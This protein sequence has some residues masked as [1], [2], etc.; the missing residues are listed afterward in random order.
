MLIKLISIATLCCVALCAG[1]SESNPVAPCQEFQSDLALTEL[2]VQEQQKQ[3]HSLQEQLSGYEDAP[4]SQTIV[5]GTLRIPAGSYSDSVFI[6]TADMK[7]ARLMGQFQE[8]RGS[9][10]FVYIFDDLNF[11]N[12]AAHADSK[13]LYNSGSVVVGEIDLSIYSP[14]TYHLVFSNR[15]SWI[16]Q[17][18]VET[19]A[20]LWFEA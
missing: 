19:T 10:L 12:W 20:D 9:D 11:K 2:V 13:A 7:K 1:C 16:T 18:I 5:K 15:H 4:E 3:I 8:V 6:V 14:G 17:K